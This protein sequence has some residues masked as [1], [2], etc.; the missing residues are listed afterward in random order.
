MM[1]AL[2]GRSPAFWIFLI[3]AAILVGA[4]S[5]S[6]HVV[7][8]Q[9]LGV[10]FPDRGGVTIWPR[11]LDSSLASLALIAFYALA[12]P[13]LSGVAPWIRV[14][15]VALLYAML[16]EVARGAA[17]GGIVTTAYLFNAAQ[18]LIPIL[19]CI[20]VAILVVAIT[21]LLRGPVAKLLGALG[22]SAL[23]LFAIRP[24]IESVLGPWLQSISYLAH[25]DVYPFPYGAHVLFW[26]YVTYLEP[27][28]ACLIIAL[29]VWPGLSARAPLRIVQFV[30]LIL[31]IKGSLIPTFLYGFYNA[32]G[33][34]LGMLSES[35][36]LLETLALALGVALIAQFA[37]SDGRARHR[38]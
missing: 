29:L 33:V 27:L 16:K 8:L 18:A 19:H 35:Q 11:L 13:R 1:N 24:L 17:M 22:I 6:I 2:R 38:P 31:L 34:P 20:A 3:A 5:L 9:G 12:Q 7:M 4:V 32:S 25:D 37:L 28:I 36:F 26:A 14:L 10:P 15:I 23:I 30:A 21:P